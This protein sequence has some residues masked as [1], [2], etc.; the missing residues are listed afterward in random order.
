[1]NYKSYV[2]ILNKSILLLCF[3]INSAVMAMDWNYSAGYSGKY[4]LGFGPLGS[5]TVYRVNIYG[6]RGKESFNTWKGFTYP[7][8]SMRWDKTCNNILYVK[9]S[10]QEE[11]S[12][13][14]SK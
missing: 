3:M 2:T 13:D 11:V 9:L 14:V 6:Y 12:V 10:N 1:M 5:V 8:E 7:V 4:V